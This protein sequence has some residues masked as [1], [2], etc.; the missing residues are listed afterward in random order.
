MNTTHV[1]YVATTNDEN[2]VVKEVS[3]TQQGPNECDSVI[4]VSNKNVKFNV[5]YQLMIKF[6][7]LPEMVDNSYTFSKPDE[8]ENT[9]IIRL[10]IEY[11]SNPLPDVFEKCLFDTLFYTYLFAQTYQCKELIDSLHNYMELELFQEHGLK[12]LLSGLTIDDL[13]NVDYGKHVLLNNWYSVLE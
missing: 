13:I 11:L 6:S 2:V 5:S 8:V 1:P 4:W 7:N 10:V 12:E 9:S 3:T